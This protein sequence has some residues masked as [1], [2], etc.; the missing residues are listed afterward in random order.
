[1]RLQRPAGSG[2]FINAPEGHTKFV[3]VD[4]VDLGWKPT[5]FGDKQ[6]VKLVGEIEELM[7]D[8]K[9]PYLVSDRYNASLFDK[10][11]LRIIVEAL[12]GRALTEA[13]V[14]D[15]DLDVLIGKCCTINVE[16][17]TNDRNQTF[18]NIRGAFKLK[19]KDGE[20]LQP[21]GHYIRIKDRT[22]TP[23]PAQP[24]N[25]STQKVKSQVN[26]R[27]QTAPAGRYPAAPTRTGNSVLSALDYVSRIQKSATK[28]EC[29]IWFGKARAQGNLSRE[30]LT[31]IGAASVS[32]K[33]AIDAGQ[34]APDDDDIPF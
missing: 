15:F 14:N 9:G 4:V 8:D 21:S 25:S 7:P 33:A 30:D 17:Y 23:P 10:S 3:L 2:D 26:N 11:H 6:M 28:D 1:M 32:R 5:N 18:A 27:P 29:N 20:P 19:P 16:H 34:S 22:D 24:S 13:E 31:N 12:L